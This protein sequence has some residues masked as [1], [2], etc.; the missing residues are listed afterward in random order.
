MNS[1]DHFAFYVCLQLWS[2]LTFSVFSVATSGLFHTVIKKEPWA[3]NGMALLPT[4]Q[5]QTRFESVMIAGLY[6]LIT[7]SILF[8]IMV[9][10]RMNST[11]LRYIISY[12]MIAMAY[13][14]GNY[15]FTMLDKKQSFMIP[16]IV[17]ENGF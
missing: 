7:T 13:V 6:L 2:S 16:R 15:Y 11:Y 12:F 14:C 5:A 1:I 17:I 3:I 8:L 4:R 10:P 9:A